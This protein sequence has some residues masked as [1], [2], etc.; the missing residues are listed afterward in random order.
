MRFAGGYRLTS[1]SS[2]H[3]FTVI[4]KDV[5]EGFFGTPATHSYWV[6]VFSTQTVNSDGK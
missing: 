1:I 6:C 2:L 5:V 4:G 3:D